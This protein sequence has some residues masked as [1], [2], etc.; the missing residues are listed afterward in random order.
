MVRQPS[1]RS[2][3]RWQN[4]PERLE[5]DRRAPRHNLDHL[6]NRK[7][8]WRK[9]LRQAG[10]EDSGILR[11]FRT[12]CSN[13]GFALG[14]SNRTRGGFLGAARE[15]FFPIL[16]LKRGKNLGGNRKRQR[17]VQGNPRDLC[18]NDSH[19]P[20]KGCF[21]RSTAGFNF[22]QPPVRFLYFKATREP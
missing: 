6:R 8:G 19:K 5:D 17:W 9:R 20:R 14:Q 4:F 7:R 12:T 2:R 11:S 10:L 22:L 13:H 18:T 15:D 21:R 16:R 1:L 3:I